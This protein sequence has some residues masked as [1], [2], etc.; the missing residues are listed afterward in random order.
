M[1]RTHKGVDGRPQ[2]VRIS[3]V[4][5]GIQDPISWFSYIEERKRIES[6]RPSIGI[7]YPNAKDVLFGRGRSFQEFGG[8]VAFRTLIQDYMDAYHELGSVFEKTLMTR[9]MA[10]MIKDRGGRFLLRTSDGW[11]V[12]GDEVVYKKIGQALR[13]QYQWK[14]GKDCVLKL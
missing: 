5:L 7:E 8:N 9:T 13:T 11:E 2:T 3:S 4:R 10:Q 14:D 1:D 12:A 6:S